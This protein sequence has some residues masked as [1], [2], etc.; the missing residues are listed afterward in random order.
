M[1]VLYE[2]QQDQ[3]TICGLHLQMPYGDITKSSSAAGLTRLQLGN[4]STC[5]NVRF[6]MKQSHHQLQD[7]LKVPLPYGDH[8]LMFQNHW[9]LE[10][11]ASHRHLYPRDLNLVSSNCCLSYHFFV[12]LLGLDR[13]NI[14]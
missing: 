14:L 6:D 4:T 1:P 10:F 2:L 3:Y 9:K 12:D 11:Y 13:M 7:V 8:Y 5:P